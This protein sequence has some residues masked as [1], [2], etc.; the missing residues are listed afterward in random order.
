VQTFTSV[1]NL[2]NSDWHYVYCPIPNSLK[3][4]VG[5]F[6]IIDNT[7]SIYDVLVEDFEFTNQNP[8]A[9]EFKMGD[10]VLSVELIDFTANY[11]NGNAVLHWQTGNERDSDHFDIERSTDGK[12]FVKTG[13]VKAFGSTNQVQNYSYL[14]AALPPLYNVFY[15]RL[16]QVDKD[17]KTEYSPIRSIRIDKQDKSTIKIYPNPN[18]GQFVATISAS[19]KETEVSIQNSRGQVIWKGIIE[20]DQ[21]SRNIQLDQ[22]TNGLYFVSCRNSQGSI[23]TIK[24]VVNR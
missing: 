12:N 17:N 14:D 22:A 13:E 24:F 20:A 18:N 1:F 11:E 3:R 19:D 8:S 10:L 15:Y 2:P 9:N 21:E 5:T 7:T 4:K 6:K 16:R 23:K